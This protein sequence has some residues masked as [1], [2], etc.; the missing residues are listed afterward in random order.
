[1]ATV[2][3]KFKGMKKL[4]NNYN[5]E[6]Q[7]IKG[8]TLEGLIHAVIVIQRTAEPGTPVDLGNLRASFFI[9][10]YKGHHG[11]LPTNEFR[12][13][14]VDSDR[15]VDVGALKSRHSKI[16][17]QASQLAKLIGND[18]QLIVVFGY[19]ANYAPYVHEKIDV[20]F[21]RPGAKARWFY[22]AIES[23]KAEALDE[24]RKYARIR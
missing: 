16:I 2:D 20:T 19:S 15:T 21:K 10:S 5:K 12:S 18:Y 3:F 8:R 23:T 9:V 24:I 11:G 17:Q 14:S 4:L 13:G 1:M 22:T 7:A 6:L